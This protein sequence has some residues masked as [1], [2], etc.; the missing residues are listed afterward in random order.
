MQK[1]FLTDWKLCGY[2]N[3]TPIIE[4]SM[5]MGVPLQGVTPVVKAKVPGSVYDALLE[6]GLIPDP[7][8]EK[9]SCLCEWVEN[10]F[11]IYQTEF[12]MEEKK[13]HYRLVF[14]GLDYRC[15]IYLNG[16]LIAQHE[17]MYTPCIV[18]VTDFLKENSQNEIRV[19][20]YN[21]PDEM[22]Q[23]GY[24]SLV[25]T[26]KARYSYKWDY[27]PR[28]VGVGIYKPVFLEE[29]EVLVQNDYFRTDPV[30]KGKFHFSF[31]LSSLK[32]RSLSVQFCLFEGEE[33]VYSR[34]K[35]INA[36]KKRSRIRFASAVHDP[37]LWY[38]HTEGDPFLYRAELKITNGTEILY[39]NE[40]FVGFKT[41]EFLPNEGASAEAPPYCFVLNGR[42]IYVHGVNISP[43]DMLYGRITK[44]RYTRLVQEAKELGAN[45]IRV[46]GGGFLESEDFYDLCDQHGILVWQ[47]FMQSSS[48]IDNH[49]SDDSKFIAK[50][51][52]TVRFAVAEKRNHVCLSVFCGGNEIA[53]GKDRIPIDENC[54]LIGKVAAYVRKHSHVH[55]VSTTPYG[56][57]FD[58]D[59]KHPENN[60]DI[61]GPWLYLGDPEQYDYC[62]RISSLFRSEFGCNG[63]SELASLKNF[64]SEK[65]IGLFNMSNNFV[66][67]HHGEVWDT[68]ERDR[69]IFGNHIKN[70]EDAIEASQFLQAEGLKSLIEC[71]R[72]QA[73]HNS[74]VMIWQLNEPFPGVSGTNLVDYYGRPKAA[75]YQVRRCFQSVYGSV[76]YDRLCY[77]EGED[78]CVRPFFIPDTDG[79]TD[80]TVRITD[81]KNELAEQKGQFNGKAGYAF[82]AE[83]ITFKVPLTP[84][85]LIVINM[86]CGTKKAENKILLLVRDEQGF[87]P[88]DYVKQYNRELRSKE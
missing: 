73:F 33:R 68:E 7:Y 29:Y 9:N 81:G 87:V 11:W 19:M 5:E 48:G 49:P 41:L 59:F 39:Q 63:M 37:K 62:K 15:D 25:K 85:I 36:D 67:R 20:F 4:R 17:N 12:R 53:K 65:N 80:W 72:K 54:K 14:Q 38:T 52:E 26:Q 84:G 56:P 3:Y 22:G 27:C 66:W 42:Q 45:I 78:C 60:W 58:H 24:T 74:G 30:Q 40:K 21:V 77:S 71:D 18:D 79:M 83:S 13:H 31:D 2:H 75:Y 86:S 16:Q 64:L 46:W 88:L 8:F 23:I 76:T 1:Q 57:F 43:L 55:F 44:E 32:E 35:R 50:F 34:T 28:L 61:H 82:E 51:M 10:R 47:D 6:A 69:K 70:I